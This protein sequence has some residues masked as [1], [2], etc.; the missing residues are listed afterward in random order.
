MHLLK[1]AQARFLGLLAALWLGVFFITRSILLLTHLSEAQ[2]SPGG[3]LRLYARANPATHGQRFT[4]CCAR[5]GS[6]AS[7]GICGC[8]RWP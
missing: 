4:C 1:S 5:T 2:L 7:A 3:V 6:G 8:C